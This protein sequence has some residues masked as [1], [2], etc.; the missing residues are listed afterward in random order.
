[1][2]SAVLRLLVWVYVIALY[3][4]IQFIQLKL[5][6]YIGSI[7]SNTQEVIWFPRVHST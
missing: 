5:T 4:E 7:M 6:V 1:M 2:I 3:E